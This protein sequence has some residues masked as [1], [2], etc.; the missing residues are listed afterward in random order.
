MSGPNTSST[1]STARPDA[2]PVSV[3]HLLSTPVLEPAR[4]AAGALGLDTPVRDVA[5]LPL[6][7][8]RS[9]EAD[10]AG[11][12]LIADASDL[13]SDHF[14]LDRALRTGHEA[15]LC[16]ILL[17]SPTGHAPLA[18]MRLADKLRLPLLVIDAQDP[19]GLADALRRQVRTPFITRS[20]AVLRAI[21]R[22]RHAQ[23]AEGVERSLRILREILHGQL[24][25]VGRD[26]RVVIGDPDSA[27]DAS[28][29]LIDVPTTVASG[30]HVHVCQP[31]HLAPREP[32]SFWLVCRL[33]APT[34]SW[35]S[36]AADV[37]GV[38]SWFVA[39]R[40]VADRLQRE[41][42]A[43]FRLGVLNAII[44]GQDRTEAA[45]TEQLGVLGWQVDGWCTA[46]HVQ[47]GDRRGPVDPARLLM[48]TGEL[49]RCLSDEGITG[50][51]VE[52]PDGWTMWVSARAEPRTTSYPELTAAIRRAMS[53]FSAG[54][55]QLRFH[56]GIG[57]PY[58][59]IGGLRTS[60]G[61]A[62]DSALVA[63][64]AGGSRGVQH[65]DEMGVRKILLGWYTSE[66]FREF[67]HTLLAPLLRSDSDGQL[68]HTLESYLDHE[69]SATETAAHLDVHRNTVLNRLERI[70]SLVTVDL[71]DPDERL[72]TQL[73]CRVLK[74][75][76]EATDG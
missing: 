63:Q 69:S 44:T 2:A 62:K 41:R 13:R 56:V 57:R 40:L 27:A 52:R 42:D 51:T 59:G 19:L 46:L 12:L 28:L 71:G 65:V 34:P 73:A 48:L 8:I 74:L 47:A 38:A 43:R 67:A 35:Q 31:L 6:D 1:S 10:L 76:R 70:R 72:A 20:D 53:R 11:V 37:L 18:T 55:T 54:D 50:P 60:L 61:E 49:R 15:G 29:E 26:G 23:H 17:C 4:V 25:L 45:L 7:A 30:A 21:E 36:V 9:R 3:R 58:H 68:L 75:D 22:L 24:A 66:A 14:Q 32:P 64:A 16:A 5:L 33:T 39:T